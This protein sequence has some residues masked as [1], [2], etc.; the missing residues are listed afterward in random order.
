MKKFNVEI[1]DCAWYPNIEAET[2]EEAKAKAWEW[3][4]ERIPTIKIEES[5]EEENDLA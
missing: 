2:E 4:I 3:F 1:S 5:E